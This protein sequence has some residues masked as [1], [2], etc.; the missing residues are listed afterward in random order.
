M[1]II[2]KSNKTGLKLHKKTTTIF[3]KITRFLPSA[4]TD[5]KYIKTYGKLACQTQSRN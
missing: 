5:N 4:V 2:N 3:K 1:Y